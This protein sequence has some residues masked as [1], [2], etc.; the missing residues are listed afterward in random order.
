MPQI[1]FGT[2]ESKNYHMLKQGFF[3]FL[4]ILGKYLFIGIAAGSENIHC[5]AQDY[6]ES[7][8]VKN[9]K[10]YASDRFWHS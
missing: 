5:S 3:Q 2:L 8:R 7:F 10:L 1:V 4:F 9:I 6:C